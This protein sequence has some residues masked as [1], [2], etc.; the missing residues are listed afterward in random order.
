MCRIIARARKVEINNFKVFAE[1]LG[2]G[3]QAVVVATY[4]MK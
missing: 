3:L 4:S 2:N 1:V